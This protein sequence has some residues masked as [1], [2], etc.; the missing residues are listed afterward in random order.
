MINRR[1][2]LII[3]ITRHLI[4]VLTNIR[5]LHLYEALKKMHDLINGQSN[6]ML[7]LSRI[8][9]V[10]QVDDALLM[11]K[12]LSSDSFIGMVKNIRNTRSCKTLVCNAHKMKDKVQ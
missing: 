9:T 5:Q 10:R 4:C 8:L 12:S 1:E 11:L 6:I 2:G 7:V 3:L